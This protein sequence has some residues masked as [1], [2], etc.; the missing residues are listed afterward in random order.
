M[1]ILSDRIA[2]QN[3]LQKRKNILFNRAGNQN[4]DILN[5]TSIHFSELLS[6][7][8]DLFGEDG[9]IDSVHPEK[10]TIEDLDLLL[11]H[12][13]IILEAEDR[14]LKS[15]TMAS[16]ISIIKVTHAHINIALVFHQA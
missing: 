2:E 13:D 12:C 9:V 14:Y 6:S 3:E 10:T 1:S 15:F 4:R 16:L 11:Q 7:V 8:T 5:S